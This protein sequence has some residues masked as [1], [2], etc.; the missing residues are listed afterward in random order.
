MEKKVLILLGLMLIVLLVSLLSLLYFFDY[1]SGNDNQGVRSED[2]FEPYFET[3]SISTC[4]N[5]NDLYFRLRY[6][7][8]WKLNNQILCDAKTSNEEVIVKRVNTEQYE[9]NG[10]TVYLLDFHLIT[11]PGKTQFDLNV[12]IN[13]EKYVIKNVANHNF[14]TEGV[15]PYSIQSTH[16]DP[17]IDSTSNQFVNRITLDNKDVKEIDFGVLS[18]KLIGVHKFD[19]HTV[20]VISEAKE[21]GIVGYYIVENGQQAC[22]ANVYHTYSLSDYD[23]SIDSISKNNYTSLDSTTE[24]N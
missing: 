8:E 10:K 2:N 18:E 16:F 17:L 11:P 4:S 15:V 3:P 1:R 5:S 24:N 6:I 22:I 21:P 9:E 13:D 23:G 14:N 12:S 20:E 7:E 19:A